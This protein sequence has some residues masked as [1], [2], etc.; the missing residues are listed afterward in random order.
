MEQVNKNK[1]IKAC[2]C[3]H[4]MD[5]SYSFFGLNRYLCSR[6]SGILAGSLLAV[7]SYYTGLQIG[8]VTALVLMMPLVFDGLLQALSLYR[9]HNFIRFMSGTLFGMGLNVLGLVR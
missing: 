8:L 9:S 1:R 4:E 5:R 6:C 3:H 2:F 7:L